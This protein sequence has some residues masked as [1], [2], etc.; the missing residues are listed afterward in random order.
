M[1]QLVDTHAHLE[2]VEN[3]E[4]ELE[5]THQAGIVSIIA[6]GSDYESNTRILEIATRY[7]RYVFPALGLHPWDLGRMS[8]AD[9]ARTLKSIEDH[10]ETIVAVG[11]IGLDYDKRVKAQVDK[12]R[13]QAVLTE[14]LSMATRLGKPVSIHSRYS[15][16]DCFEL[17]RAAGVEK[18]VFHWFTGFS[19]VLQEILSAGYFISATPAAEYHA[20]H[21]RAIK[22]AP[23]SQ[24]LLET[25]SPVYYGREQ[26]YRSAPRDL[27]RSL[28]A[29]AE[30][31]G[32]D[33]ATVAEKTT[34]NAIRLFGMEEKP[35]ASSQ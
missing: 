16:K 35:V 23:L 14:L 24:L 27:L 28:N 30:I 8:E 32:V 9:V 12:T 25:D 29:V 11:E 33:R 7:P 10:K 2:T 4:Q 6:V 26:R 31:K 22:E 21:R 3:L 5:A 17:V 19:S 34:E 20:E 15:W 1:L 13:Q 18:A